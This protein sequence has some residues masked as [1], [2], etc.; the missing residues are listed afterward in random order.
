MNILTFF[1]LC[2]NDNYVPRGQEGYNPV[3]KLGTIYSAVTGNFQMSRS[4]EKILE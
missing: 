1:H 3:K 2:D 4:Q